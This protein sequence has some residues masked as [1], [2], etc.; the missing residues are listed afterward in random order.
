MSN[1]KAKRPAERDLTPLPVQK[2]HQPES[3]GPKSLVRQVSSPVTSELSPPLQSDMPLSRTLTT[4]FGS[5]TQSDQS[6]SQS[7]S[8]FSPISRPQT[9]TIAHEKPLEITPLVR[10]ESGQLHKSSA[11]QKP[12]KTQN[13]SVLP[14]RERSSRIQT[15][16][17]AEFDKLVSK[18]KTTG[19]TSTALSNDITPFLMLP[20]DPGADSR[21]YTSTEAR[22]RINEKVDQSLVS[23]KTLEG[24]NLPSPALTLRMKAHQNSKLMLSISSR[25]DVDGFRSGEDFTYTENQ[26]LSHATRTADDTPA[27]RSP[28]PFSTG[29][30]LIPETRYEKTHKGAYRFSGEPGGTVHAPTQANQV[31]DTNLERFVA[32]QPG[33][34]IFRQD[35]YSTS[36]LW[37]V[38][39]RDD[40]FQLKTA[41]YQ[42]RAVK[43][44]EKDKKE[45]S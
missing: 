20:L 41:S 5:L 6:P 24:L 29:E 7:L 42:R 23:A 32:Q 39:P 10:S 9:K 44:P 37:A 4:P 13:L 40:G 17:Q 34:F 14:K 18:V 3:Q 38:R 2:K 8:L 19:G 21:G 15:K 33:S 28:S 35:T 12:R 36:S 30:E 31:V 45:E 16:R 27:P 43:E 11:I 1:F 22:N 25:S 26:N